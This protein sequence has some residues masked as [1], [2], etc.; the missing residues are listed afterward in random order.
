LLVAGGGRDLALGGVGDGVKESAEQAVG[1]GF[2]FAAIDHAFSQHVFHA[3]GDAA[4]ATGERL[5]PYLLM[6]GEAAAVAD[7]T[8]FFFRSDGEHDQLNVC[9][10][11]PVVL[12]DDAAAFLPRLA[13]VP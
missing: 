7:P 3:R 1:D 12:D 2:G 10:G 11:G 6:R 9:L 8:E 13:L 5:E 4:L